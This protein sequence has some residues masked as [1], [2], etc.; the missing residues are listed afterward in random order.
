VSV[1]FVDDALVSFTGDFTPTPGD[2]TTETS[3][4][5]DTASASN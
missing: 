3:D 5:P 1:N 4:N 2:E